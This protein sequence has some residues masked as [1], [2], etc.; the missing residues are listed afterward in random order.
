MAK[1]YITAYETQSEYDAVKDTLP[2]PH[3]ALVE[4]TMD[5]YYKSYDY[6]DRYLAFVALENGTFKFSGNSINYS[7]DG[8]ETWVELASNTD[9]P[10]VNEGD[11]IM[12]KASGLTISSSNGI[13]RFS[14]SGRF[15]VEGNVM[16]LLY[17]DEFDGEKNL[18][19]KY[20]AFYKLFSGCTNVISAERM[21]LLA[22]TLAEGCYCGMFYGCTSLTTE[23]ELPATMMAASAYTYMFYGCTSLTTAPSLPATTLADYC[24]SYMFQNCSNLT[25]APELL[26][27][28]LAEG[29]YCG[30]FYGCTSLT[31]APELSATTL[32]SYCYIDMFNSCG[33]TTAPSLPAT[34][35]AE[36]CYC[37]MFYGCTSLTTAPELPATM[38]AASAYSYMFYGCSSLTVAPSLPATTL[39]D[40][41]YEYMFYGC[42]SLT[43]APSLPAT[44]LV[45]NCYRRMFQGCTSL[46]T[47]PELLAET[48]VTNCYYRMFYNCRSL[49]YIKMGSINA[50]NQNGWVY[51]VA[52][53][54]TF[55]MNA[56]AEWS[57][58]TT[59]CGQSTYPCSWTVETYTPS[60]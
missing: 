1:E 9:S 54:G 55:V 11:K 52:S 37:G 4:E 50:P 17:G 5:V 32:A 6:S 8:G 45:S 39:A 58:S 33:L 12:W 47:A 22:T 60:S 18:G 19:G 43:V 3:V 49:N 57:T 30:M 46:T 20:Y 16:S 21:S 35:L 31:T 48:L 40:Y 51:G 26:A 14:S 34:T 28:T 27:T 53:S 2:T 36:G 59:S 56:N 29:C 25:T 7:I 24:Y 23:P 41:C 15:E 38:M 13:G 10:T 44:T 42:S